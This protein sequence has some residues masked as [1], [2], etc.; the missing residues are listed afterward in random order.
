[1]KVLKKIGDEAPRLFEDDIVML[2]LPLVELSD[3]EPARGAEAVAAFRECRDSVGD[4]LQAET[5]MVRVDRAYERASS[6]GALN[7][8]Q[9]AS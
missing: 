6:P 1:M 2:Q 9:V 7:Q 4:L 3:D 8:F 5:P